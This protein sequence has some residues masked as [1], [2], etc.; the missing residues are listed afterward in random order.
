MI[1]NINIIVVSRCAIL[2]YGWKVSREIDR[3]VAQWLVRSWV[4]FFFFMSKALGE[5]PLCG[6]ILKD[7]SYIRVGLHPMFLDML[8]ALCPGTTQSTVVD[9]GLLASMEIRIL[10]VVIITLSH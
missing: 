10:I 6:L 1:V 9:R 3:Y 8:L 7:K 2:L 4:F 5:P